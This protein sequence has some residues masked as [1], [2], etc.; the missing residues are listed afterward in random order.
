MDLTFTRISRK[1]V[2]VDVSAL[3]A[4]GAPATLTGAD[5]ALINPPLTGATE[6]TAVDFADGVARFL[7]AGPDADPTGAFVLPDGGAYV[8]L[9]VVDNPETDVARVG[10]INVSA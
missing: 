1:Y 8:Y 9:R 7:V 4:D 3:L 10:R 6:W 5:V 2:E